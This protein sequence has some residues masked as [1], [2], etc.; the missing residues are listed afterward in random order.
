MGRLRSRNGSLFRDRSPGARTD[1]R[2]V[3][4]RDHRIL[5]EIAKCSSVKPFVGDENQTLPEIV[6]SPTVF[7]IELTDS[8]G[9]PLG[10]DGLK[11]M[12]HQLNIGAAG[13]RF[14]LGQ[15]VR[16]SQDRSGDPNRPWRTPGHRLCNGPIQR[17][18]PA[19]S[20]ECSATDG[21]GLGSANPDL[22]RVAERTAR[23]LGHGLVSRSNLSSRSAV[24]LAGGP[25]RWLPE[26][27]TSIR[28]RARP[29]SFTGPTVETSCRVSANNFA[30]DRDQGEP[31]CRNPASLC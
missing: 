2:H 16:I 12:H 7:A 13:T 1:R 31:G 5:Y 24:H 29:R 19:R 20:S 9:A 27:A 18:S 22:G 8:T 28:S 6:K 3:C 4:Q 26:P 25:T 14:H 21:R 30:R 17:K 11:A 15:P 10:Y 23:E